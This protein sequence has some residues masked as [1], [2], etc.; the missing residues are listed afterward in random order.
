MHILQSHHANMCL[1]GVFFRSLNWLPHFCT[2]FNLVVTHASFISVLNYNL[3][4]GPLKFRFLNDKSDHIRPTYSDTQIL[5][6]DLAL[7]I[8]DLNTPEAL[9]AAERATAGQMHEMDVHEDSSEDDSEDDFDDNTDKL[10]TK[11]RS[12]AKKVNIIES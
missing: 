2:L 7:G 6:Q 11:S 10:A 5:V 8:A 4:R 12:K 1:F 9:A 3:C